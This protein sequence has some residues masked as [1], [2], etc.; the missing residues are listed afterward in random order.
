MAD[1]IVAEGVEAREIEGCNGWYAVSRDGRIWTNRV[2]NRWKQLKPFAEKAYGHLKVTLFGVVPRIRA[3]HRLVLES[4][5]GPCPPGMEC[6]HFPDRDVTNNRLENLQWG[7]RLENQAD[8]FKHGTAK[9]GESHYLAKFSNEVAKEIRRRYDGGESQASLSRAF[10]ASKSV[11]RAIVIG[12]TYRNRDV[13]A[14][15][16]ETLGRT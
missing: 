7:T 12:K 15:P 5:V 14:E 6:R 11:I 3:V 9:G 4:F 2:G 13:R 1:V 16:N 10:N 8:R